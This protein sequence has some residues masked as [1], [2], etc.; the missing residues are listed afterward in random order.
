MAALHW[1]ESLTLDEVAEVLGTAPEHI[2][3]LHESAV[4]KVAAAVGVPPTHGK[5]LASWSR[6]EVDAECARPWRQYDAALAERSASSAGAGPPVRRGQDPQ[7]PGPARHDRSIKRRTLR[8][9]LPVAARGIGPRSAG[10]GVIVSI[11]V[12]SALPST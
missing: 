11:E 1:Y 5:P 6:V 7:G 12:D 4:A 9:G 2:A 8:V 3:A 10:S